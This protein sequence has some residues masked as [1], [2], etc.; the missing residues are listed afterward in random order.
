HGLVHL[1]H[2]QEAG[3]AAAVHRNFAPAVV[4]VDVNAVGRLAHV[5]ALETCDRDAEPTDMRARADARRG[6]RAAAARCIRGAGAEAHA[7][8]G[9]LGIDLAAPQ[10]PAH[11]RA[12]AVRVHAVAD[13]PGQFRSIE[14]TVAVVDD[15]R[16]CAVFEFEIGGEIAWTRALRHP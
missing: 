6:L 5:A 11:S 8:L 10:R 12:L 2:F 3:A 7:F 4:A 16:G 14:I 1:A 9:G 15:G 13:T